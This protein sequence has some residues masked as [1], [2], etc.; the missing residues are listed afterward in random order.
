MYD[1]H[2][3]AVVAY[4]MRR[5]STSDAMD[6]V[7]ETFAVAWRRIDDVPAGEA[8]KSWLYA[9]AHR[10]L[11]NQRRSSRRLGNLRARL[12]GAGSIPGPEPV[13]VLVQA[14]EARLLLEALSRLRTSDQEV[15]RLITWEE[16]P[17]D[18]VARILKIS[19]SALDQRLHRATK[20]LRKEYGT[21]ARP[22]DASAR[23]AEGGV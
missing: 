8:E 1:E 20:R 14:E 22:S 6:A 21:I 23:I 12:R 15:L 4:C 17:R 19:R 18:E 10:V 9:V 11:L 13:E 16:H 2:R 7:A 3:N 5:T